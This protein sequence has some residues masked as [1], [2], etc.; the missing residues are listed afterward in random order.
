MNSPPFLQA[1]GLTKIY[2]INRHSIE[3]LKGITLTIHKGEFVSIIGASGVGKSTFLHILGALDTPTSGEIQFEGKNI[4]S[5]NEKELAL[6]RNRQVGFVFQFHHLLPEF[7][8][9]E[10]GAMPALIR[11]IPKKEALEMARHLLEEVGLGKRLHHKPGELSGGE[12]Q[13]V[14]VARA[15]VLNPSLILADEPTGNLDSKTSEEVFQLMRKL[16]R[17]KK[18][19]L[20]MVTHNEKL[21]VQGD[22]QFEMVDGL[23]YEIKRG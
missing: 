2:T 4:Y 13:R 7:T 11:G 17:E 5:G 16:N 8:A 6:F 9:L 3:V 12:Q 18:V 21:S 19:T 15:M 10:N 23:I 20:V 22:R 1:N 14:A